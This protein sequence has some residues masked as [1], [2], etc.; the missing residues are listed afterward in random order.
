MLI[1]DYLKTHKL[2]MDGAMGTYYSKLVND[3]SAIA[4]R[5]NLQNPEIILN[6]HKEYI[7]SG[8]KLLRTNTFVA[9]KEILEI[10]EAEQRKLIKAGYQIAKEAAES[11][12]EEVYIAADIGPIPENAE[13]EYEDILSEYKVLIDSF[14]EV[15]A[16][17]FLFETFSDIKYIAPLVKYIKQDKESDIFIITNFCLNKNGYTKS[18]LSAKRLLEEIRDIKEIDAVGFN[19]GIGSGHMY[20]IL[21]GLTFPSNKYLVSAPNSS[22]PEQYQNRLVYLDNANY[23]KDKMQKIAA[24]DINIIGGCCGSTPLHIKGLD[25]MIDMQNHRVL[26][27]Y[28]ADNIE[29]IVTEQRKNEF[30]EKLK[31]G[32]KVIA[33]ELDPPFDEKYDKVMEC[34]HQLKEH[35]VDMIT[36]A[37]SPMG[38]SRVDSILMSLKL[39]QELSIPVMP[40]VCCR[41]KNMIAMR[42]GLLGAYINGI[43]NILIVTGDPVPSER[44]KETTSVFDY[45]SIQLMDY[46]KEM[47]KEHFSEEPI[48]YGAALNY[49]RG[50]IDKV[51]E[52]MNK[53]IAAG[54]SYFL[55]Q[56][57]YSDEDID[58]IREIK[59]RVD[60]KILCGIMPLV[61][62]R[63]ANFIKNEIAGIHVPD[64]IVNRYHMDMSKEE[65]EM[66]GATISNEIIEKLNPFAD[67][68]Y[69]MLPFN[70]VSLMDKIKID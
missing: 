45:N 60:T 9:S 24:L 59:S 3:E 38:R 62:Y 31:S 49:G 44:K 35:G 25:T 1:R 14:L 43:R 67:G 53:K 21:E 32:K 13:S 4:E 26:S 40:H 48:Y 15:G 61:S 8:A 34:A 46:V 29:N 51:I 20:Q 68:Y 63:N 54:A 18:G 41:D 22:Y 6:I 52:R 17:I 36:M 33:V 56:P 39:K 28:S 37:D 16:T 70:R 47:N 10:T 69:F 19:C 5:A 64:D 66:V 42:S 23:F 57:I 30:Y 58:R 2:I 7:A 11:S 50:L 65:A 55:T 27:E 12:S